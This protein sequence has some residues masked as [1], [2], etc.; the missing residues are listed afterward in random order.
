MAFVSW[1]SSVD[2]GWGGVGSGLGEVGGAGLGWGRVGRVGWGGKWV[3]VGG[4]G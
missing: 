1:V 2:K 4:T 3:G